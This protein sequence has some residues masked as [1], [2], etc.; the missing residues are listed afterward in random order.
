MK[1]INTLLAVTTLVVVLAVG[2]FNSTFA[3]GKGQQKK[4][5]Q[6][7]TL[8]QGIQS[9]NEG[10]RRSSIYLAG[11]YAIAEAV[12]ALVEEL[13]QEDEASNKIL[14]SL[15]LYYIGDEAGLEKVK[16]LVHKDTDER[17]R[18]MAYA[19]YDTFTKN[20][21]SDLSVR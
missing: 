14:I 20:F 3:A 18:R 13:K 21:S 1:R 15:A 10:L 7:N 6:V 16:E 9:E 4:A 2:S 11:R 12:P 8:I 19:I 17:V 5:R